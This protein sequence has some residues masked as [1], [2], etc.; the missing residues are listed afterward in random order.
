[1]TSASVERRI[2]WSA[3]AF[4]DLVWPMLAGQFPGELMPVESVSDST[5]AKILDQ[6]AGID[7]WLLR[8]NRGPVV[9]IASRVQ[10][11]RAGRPFDTFTVRMARPWSQRPQ[12]FE[13]LRLAASSTGAISPH[14]MVHA[15]LDADGERVLSVAIARRADVVAAIEARIGFERPNSEDGTVFWCLPWEGEWHGGH[16]VV[17]REGDN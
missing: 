17:R 2:Q 12:E 13:R 15:Y 8:P 7:A 16:I 6:R 14:Y 4:R 1:M 9:G 11:C 5:F 10:R 3:A